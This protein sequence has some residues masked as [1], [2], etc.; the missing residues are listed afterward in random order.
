MLKRIKLIQG[1]GSYR[2]VR[3]SGFELAKV[4]II[5][6]E[7]RNGKSTL[8]DILHSL[9]SNNPE[10]VLNREAIPNDATNPPKV[11][12]LFDENGSNHVACFEHGSWQALEPQSSKLYVFDQSFI[13]RNIITG[14]KQE[15]QNSENITSFILGEANTALFRQL[16][17]LN[18]SVRDERSNHSVIEGQLRSHSI[19]NVQEYANSVLPDKSK[20]ELEGEATTQ[21]GREQQIAATIQ[22]IDTIKQRAILTVIAKQTDY[23]PEI[24]RINASITSSLQNVH[25]DALASLDNHVTNH[26]ND[27]SS[28][29]GWAAQGLNLAKDTSCPFCGQGLSDSAKSLL[30]SYQKVFNTEFDNFNRNTKQELDQL[31][32]PFMIPDTKENIERLHLSNITTISIYQEPEVSAHP[33]F[34]ELT[35]SLQQRYDELLLAY[36][37]LDNNRKLAVEFWIPLLNQKYGVPYDAMQSIDFSVLVEIEAAYNKAIYDYWQECEKINLLLNQYKNSVDASQLRIDM[38]AMTSAYNTTM[39][40]IKRID[41]DALCLQYKTKAQEISTL[42]SSYNQRKIQLEQS[43]STYLENYFDLV[44]QLFTALGSNDFEI[45]RVENN[46]GHQ[47]VYELRIN[48]KGQDV[49]VDKVN[50]V[51]SESDR[52]ALALCVFLAKI[53]SLSPEEK[54]KAILVFDDP[55]TS[56]DNERITLILNKFDELIQNVK[57][58]IITTHYKGMASKA[59]RKFRQVAKSIKLTQ[60]INGIE[61]NVVENDTMTASDH[62]VAFDRIK[63]FAGRATNDNIMTELRPF[64]EEEI[65]GRYKNQLIELGNSKDDLAVCINALRD[66]DIMSAALA[67]ELNAIRDSLNVPMHEI[68]QDAVENTRAVAVQILDVVYNRL[69]PAA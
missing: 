31:R 68:G 41:L 37:A 45:I 57:Q 16:A 67:T 5:Y 27:S 65:R 49:P 40:L 63:S 17:D 30:S 29:K 38:S 23:N 48:F 36:D 25:Q 61:M 2:Q 11:E 55:V 51:F 39:E 32:Q 54:S 21:K 52:R 7:N 62:D 69:T 10:L 1:I 22:N 3:G 44:N 59:V 18:T 56:F 35:S 14:Q 64:F 34:G 8:C 47:V 28:F 66:N 58:L 15:R 4:N 12:I 50:Y 13:H 6:G 24:T 53:L 60:G 19:L 9:E 46:R 20:S 33:T 42:E 26:V 43:Q